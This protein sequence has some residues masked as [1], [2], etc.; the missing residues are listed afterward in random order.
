MNSNKEIWIKKGYE[1][2][3]V[4]G[5]KELKIERLAKDVG[6]S[7]SSFYH[8][9]G[10]LELFIEALLELHLSQSQIIFEKEQQAPKLNLD[11]ILIFVEHKLDLLFGKQLMLNQNVEV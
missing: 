1:V 3:A 5:P 7:K 2:F 10:D 8:Y 9:F 6:K 4:Y 11:I